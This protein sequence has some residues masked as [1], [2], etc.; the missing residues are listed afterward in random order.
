MNVKFNLESCTETTKNKIIEVG[1]KNQITYKV[2]KHTDK[3]D[4]Q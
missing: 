4:T 2:F 1:C 3:E